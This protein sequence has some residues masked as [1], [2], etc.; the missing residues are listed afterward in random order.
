MPT[1]DLSAGTIAYDDTGGSG[2]IV[3]LLHGLVMDSSLWRHV[4]RDLRADHRCVAPTLPLGA[5]RHPMRAHAD[6]SPQ[7]IGRLVAEFIEKLGL[8][9]VTLVGNDAGLC[10]ITAGTYPERIGRLVLTSCEAFENFPAGLPGWT[11]ALAAGLPG[12][13]NALAQPMRLRALRRLPV[14]FGWMAKRPIPHAVTDAWLRP[15][16]TQ[17][18]IRR[19]LTAYLRSSKR[20]DMLVAAEGL[21]SFDRPALVIWA[22][23]DRVMPPAH[24]R[25]L[26]A[27]LPRGRLL[28]IADSYTLIPED[29]SGELAQAIRQFIRDAP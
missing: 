26:A 13:L 17:R 23:E 27:L 12:G 21:R 6:L 16:L 10:Q 14:A 9:D 7:G 8:Q 11:V 18:A 25:R 15:V 24:G 5:H 2:P 28:E 4:V 19:D 1:I 3:V 20:G 29:Q 22:Q